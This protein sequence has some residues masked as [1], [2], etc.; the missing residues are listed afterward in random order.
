[1]LKSRRTHLI[2][3]L[4]IC[5]MALFLLL[6]LSS[7]SD[8][9]DTWT[10]PD[11]GPSPYYERVCFE[12]EDG[13]SVYRRGPVVADKTGVDVSEYQGDI[14]WEAVAS[15]GI[16]F[17]FI[18]IGNRGSTEGGLF[19]DERYDYN[20]TAAQA[21]GIECGVYFFSQAI[22]VE[23]A[24]EE[25]AFVLE[26]LGGRY[27]DYPVAFDYEVT[28]G[29]RIASIKSSEMTAIA[30][31]FCSVIEAG[32]YRAMLYGNGY[33]LERFDNELRS[34]YGI[35]FAEYGDSPSYTARFPIWQYTNH[36]SVSGIASE[37]DLNLD[38]T[39]VMN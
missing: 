38:L 32:G 14:D 12:Q 33:D 17:V 9:E 4:V 15:D 2:K 8:R 30:Q 23:E 16:D 19:V 31:A 34:S 5:M 27:L 25:A 24:Q 29:S 35:W 10:H 37:V 7:C 13:R 11:Q 1:M 18:R 20:L 6:S 39:D 36:G 21:A 22:S 3:A 26:L 28:S